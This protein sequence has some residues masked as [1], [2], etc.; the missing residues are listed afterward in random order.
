M[1]RFGRERHT[2]LD[3]AAT[4]EKNVIRLNIT[5][6]DVLAVEMRKTFACLGGVLV[7]PSK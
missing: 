5:M 7:K 4:V 1:E 6:N 2:D 3:I